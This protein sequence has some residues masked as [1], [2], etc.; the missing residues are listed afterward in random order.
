MIERFFG[1]D[2]ANYHSKDPTKQQKFAAFVDT[3]GVKDQRSRASPHL[4]PAGQ[5]YFRIFGVTRRRQAPGP[6]QRPSQP[7]G[8]LPGRL[9][10]KALHVATDCG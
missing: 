2:P 1:G 4:D 10:A 7:R 5:N 9:P 8:G 6:R 3:C